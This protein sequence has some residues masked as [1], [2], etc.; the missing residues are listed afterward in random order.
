MARF[1]IRFVLGYFGRTGP[2][3]LFAIG[4]VLGLI[5]CGGDGAVTGGAGGTPRISGRVVRADN[6]NAGVPGVTVTVT[7]SRSLGVGPVPAYAAVPRSRASSAET[8]AQGNFQ[9]DV[10]PG[11]VTLQFSGSGMQTAETHVDTSGGGTVP[12]S[13]SVVP[14][15]KPR[16][17]QLHVDPAEITM[18]VNSTKQLALDLRD[19]NNQPIVDLLPAWSLT[20]DIGTMNPM[21]LVFDGAKMG[22]T[23]L[24]ARIGSVTDTCNLTVTDDRGPGRVVGQVTDSSGSPI[25]G[26]T[27]RI[28]ELQRTEA[29]GSDGRFAFGEVDGGDYTATASLDGYR[30]ESKLVAVVG[31]T[32]NAANFTLYQ[33]VPL[34]QLRLISGNAPTQVSIRVLG[35]FVSGWEFSSTYGTT[36]DLAARYSW[37]EATLAAD[38]RL[39]PQRYYGGIDVNGQQRWWE[40]VRPGEGGLKVGP[41]DIRGAV[42]IQ[43]GNDEGSAFMDPVVLK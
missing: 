34:T 37:F 10:A 22:T 38:D 29:S 18:E 19:V 17:I 31:G 28:V 43:P 3:T 39:Q 35:E 9:V 4:V 33:I 8:D 41:I 13:I 12:M 23:V 42:Q 30:T 40:S 14:A 20:R 15:D 21:S 6:P 5:G 36:Y 16:P 26:A 25:P 2:G 7:R 27:L 24:M 1:S 32:D 11:D